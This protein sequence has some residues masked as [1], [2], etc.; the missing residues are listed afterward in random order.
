MTVSAS[1]EYW[2]FWSNSSGSGSELLHY[3]T[4]PANDYLPIQINGTTYRY[5]WD[6]VVDNSTYLVQYV[7]HTPPLGLYWV[8]AATGELIPTGPLY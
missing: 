1:P 7:P 6:I 4:Q 2:E 8:D 5:I 3:V